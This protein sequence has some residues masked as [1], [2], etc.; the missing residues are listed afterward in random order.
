M[1][2]EPRS[3]GGVERIR[4]RTRTKID[5]EEDTLFPTKA[6]EVTPRICTTCSRHL[7]VYDVII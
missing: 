7:W 5:L 2:R 6:N 3:A 4:T 1:G